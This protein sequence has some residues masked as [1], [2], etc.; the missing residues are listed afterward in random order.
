MI[1]FIED[2]RTQYGVEP[3]CAVLPIAPSTYYEHRLAVGTRHGARLASNAT[4]GCGWRSS[5]STTPATT[6]STGPRRS[7][8]SCTGSGALSLVAPWSG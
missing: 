3:I 7:G 6:A 8:A 4:S 1:D 5:A 2:N